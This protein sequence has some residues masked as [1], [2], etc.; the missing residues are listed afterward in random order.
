MAEERTASISM[1]TFLQE[2]FEYRSEQRYSTMHRQKEDGAPPPSS[3]AEIRRRVPLV[4]KPMKRRLRVFATD[5]GDS[6]KMESAFTNIATIS[7][8]WERLRRGPT[9]EYLEVID[10]DPPSNLAYS[11]VDLDDRHLLAQDGH[12]PSEGHPQFHQQMV[13]AVAMRTIRNFEVALGRRILWSERRLPKESDAKYSP[14]PDGGYVQ[15][16]RIYPPALRERNAYYSPDKKALPSIWIFCVRKATERK[17]GVHV[18]V[19]RHHH[20]RD[21]ARRPGRTSSTVSRRY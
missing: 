15:R 3:G 16:L 11:P 19:A 13:Y 9:G 21:N 18:L 17:D 12:A 20:A 14:A 2:A 1:R 8:P 10:I 7:V 4:P 6:D 5:P